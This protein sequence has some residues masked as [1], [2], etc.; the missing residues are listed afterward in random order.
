MKRRLFLKHAAIAPAIGLAMNKSAKAGGQAGT[1]PKTAPE[2]P[3]ASERGR[4]RPGRIQNEY[5]LFLPGEREALKNSPRVSQIQAC[6]VKA[7]LGSEEKSLKLGDAIGG[8]RLVAVLPW[9]NGIA[10]AAFEKHVTH[11]GAIAYVTEAGEIAHIPKRVGDLSKIRPRPTNSPH[12]VKFER[13]QPYVPG[14]D[15]LGDYI[16]NS[17]ED[18]CYENLAALGPEMIGWTFLGN[19]EGGTKK[20]LWLEADGTSRQFVANPDLAWLPDLIERVFVP[21]NFLPSVFRAYMRY[22]DLYAYVP[23]YSKRTLLGGYLPAAD[24]G[25]W[26]PITQVGYE[27]MV[28]L[29]AGADARPLG[30]IRATLP[31]KGAGRLADP[32]GIY[33]G[34][35]CLQCGECVEHY[36]NGTAA[37]FFTNLAGIWGHWQHFFEDKMKV[38]IPDDWL[39]DA[40]RA[41]ITLCRCSYHGL[42]P[43]YQIGEGP[44]C[45]GV[46]LRNFPVAHYGFVW[47]QQLWNL[48]EEVEPYFQHYL[49]HLILADGNFLFNT[50]DQVDATA[51]TGVFL[52]VSARAYDYTHD[53]GALRKRL[54]VLRRMVDFVLRRYRYTKDHFPADD[55]RHGLIWGSP[56]ADNG[57][58]RDDN[59]ES[60]AYYYQNASWTWRGLVEH[61]RCLERAG[62][63][64]QDAA[65]QQEAAE[66]ASVAR[67]MRADIELSLR[68]T[69]AD[70]SPEMKRAGI[71]PITAFDTGRLPADLGSY[72]NHRYM[73]DWWT[74]DWG[75]PELDAGH[76]R[77]RALA[78]LQILGMNT[79]QDYPLTS[80]FMEHGTLAGRI[81][82]E[83]YRPFL[84]TL[85]ANLC[86][87]MDCGNRYAPED[88]LI[89]GSFPG[90]GNPYGWA[91]VINSELL[92]TIGLRWLLCYEEHD[93]AAVHLQKAAPKHW[94]NPGES[95]RVTDCPTRFGHLSWRTEASGPESEPRWRVT[96]EFAGSF[97]ADLIV[98]IHPPSRSPLKKASLGEIHADRVV[99]PSSLLRETRSVT[100]EVA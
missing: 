51:D 83:D 81:R 50:Q 36:W 93:R 12:G 56:E 92:P 99:L 76:F 96:I 100:L 75:D 28:I 14:P 30:R 13:P 23:G 24:I 38:E 41:G 59:P 22:P 95:I 53:I 63:E 35:G 60:Q 39:L 31:P 91:A 16:L 88:A 40:A 73:M 70:R 10:T 17:A 61:G 94:F 49:E 72:E 2:L 82:Q 48:T 57:D 47:A 7:R 6:S 68:K 33:E 67:E 74:S 21:S 77:H 66:V 43:T 44:Y 34:E 90:D 52:E 86:F 27:V 62:A 9:L 78:G 97:G 3:P 5:S 69:L 20:S 46:A 89:P 15:V 64:H 98:H 26:N 18:P 80:N 37:E 71:T 32:G 58:P 11:Q 54:P 8:W 55:P 65:L 87:A 85:Y 25:V 79:N 29:P 19:E 84:L 1:G 45:R 4:Y 42:E